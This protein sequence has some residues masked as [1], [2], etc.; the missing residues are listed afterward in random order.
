MTAYPPYP[1]LLK[2]A[3][4]VLNSSATTVQNTIP[5]QY[6]PDNLTRTLQVQAAESESDERTEALR[7]KGAPEE[8]IKVEVEI[9]A[10]D[11]LENLENPATSEGIYPQL[12]ALE[13]LIYPKSVDVKTNTRESE[14]GRLEIIPLE[15]PITLFVW[16]DKRLLPVRIQKFSI[17]EQAY[18]TNLNP[19]RA[20]VSLDLRVLSYNDLLWSESLSKLFFRHH[21]DKEKMAKRSYIK[22]NP[23]KITGVNVNAR[24]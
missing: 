5:F 20:Q 3:I 12:S 16:G 9:D 24:F 19:I 7:L 13:L 6:N 17:T 14:N 8:T 4:V 18:D 2:G 21:Q 22:K 15:A 10:T 23:S 1:R 11:Q